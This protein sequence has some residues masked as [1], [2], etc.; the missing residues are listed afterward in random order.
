VWIGETYRG[1]LWRTALEMSKVIIIWAFGD[2]TTIGMQ[3]MVEDFVGIPI[4]ILVSRR[5]LPS[6]ST[7]LCKDR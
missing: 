4:A 1:I 6:R 2:P 3:T 5:I 7:L